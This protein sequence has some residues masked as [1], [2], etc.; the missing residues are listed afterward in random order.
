MGISRDKSSATPNPAPHRSIG[1]TAQVNSQRPSGPYPNRLSACCSHDSLASLA[2]M[3]HKVVHANLRQKPWP[4]GPTRLLPSL[5]LASSQTGLEGSLGDNAWH[6]QQ[7]RRL[8]QA[9][10]YGVFRDERPFSALDCR[11]M[12]GRHTPPDSPSLHLPPD[13]PRDGDR[14]DRCS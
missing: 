5:F 6:L 11:Q 10:H 8:F 3:V 2:H 9:G 12:D 13:R 14:P 4:S 7:H 1:H